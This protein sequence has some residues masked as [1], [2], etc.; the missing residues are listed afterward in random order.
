ML[1]LFFIMLSFGAPHTD[2]FVENDV[3]YSQVRRLIQF[4]GREEVL[5]KMGPEAYKHLRD[6]MMASNEEVEDRWR[7]T[8]ALAK[9]GGED[10]IP[11][12]Q[13]A[14]VHND[15]FM[16]SAGLLGLALAKRDLAEEKA[17]EVLHNDPA[18]LVRAAALQV[19]AQQKKL[20]KELLWAE[21]YNPIN[22]SNGKGLPLRLSLLKVL[23]QHVTASDAA[24]L[25]ALMREDNSEIQEMAKASLAKIYED[26]ATVKG[27]KVSSR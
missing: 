11:D 20:D 12:L 23:E 14:L 13:S 25:T 16:R 24:K 17:K 26:K 8:M 18:L 15:W 9:I 27:T 4:E 6:L 3:T 7:A 22:F 10:S 2:S 19:L 21:I 5:K 1:S